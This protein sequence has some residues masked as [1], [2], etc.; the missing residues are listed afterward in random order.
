MKP[1]LAISMLALLNGCSVLPYEEE[2][3]CPNAAGTGKCISVDGAY[4]E[5]VKGEPLD[6]ADSQDVMTETYGSSLY[7]YEAEQYQALAGLLRE[8]ETPLVMP[9][10]V[11]RTLIL[12][13]PDNPQSPSRLY[14]PRFV[15]SIDQKPQFVFGQ[16]KLQDSIGVDIFKALKGGDNE[17][18]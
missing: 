4:E 6:K 16:Y 15:Y 3:Q 17:S 11:V 5:A 7:E 8:P 18:N 9:A 12:S 1:V 10:R 13:Y 14:M 2:F